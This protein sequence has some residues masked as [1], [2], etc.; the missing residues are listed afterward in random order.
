MNHKIILLTAAGDPVEEIVE[1]ITK[2]GV[3]KS[4]FMQLPEKALH[5]GVRVL[6]A[7]LCFIIGF[8]VQAFQILSE[9]IVCDSIVGKQTGNRTVVLFE[10]SQK[11]MLRFYIR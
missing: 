9:T 6:I 7:V 5:L 4:F 1:E 2:P 10:Q 8:S 3:V 11:H